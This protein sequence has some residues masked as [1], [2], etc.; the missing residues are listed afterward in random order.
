MLNLFT[1]VYFAFQVKGLQAE[2]DYTYTQR[3]TPKII[4]ISVKLATKDFLQ[5]EAQRPLEGTWTLSLRNDQSI[6]INI[7]NIDWDGWVGGGK[8]VVVKFIIGELRG[9]LNLSRLHEIF[10]NCRGKRLASLRE[11]QTEY[12]LYKTKF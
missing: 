6:S 5:A 1:F 2:V 12:W 9:A 11:S 10:Q 3:F 8:G 4:R 7:K